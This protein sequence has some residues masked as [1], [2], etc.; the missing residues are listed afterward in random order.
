ML[1]SYWSNTEHASYLP[2]LYGSDILTNKS[3]ASCELLIVHLETKYDTVLNDQC[4]IN[5]ISLVT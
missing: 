3:H 5:I 4:K 1:V 2:R